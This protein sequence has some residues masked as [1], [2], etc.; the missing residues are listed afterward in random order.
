MLQVKNKTKTHTYVAR[1]PDR[2]ILLIACC[3]GQYIDLSQTLLLPLIEKLVPSSPL[4]YERV[5]QLDL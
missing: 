3:I 1:R 5:T 2:K 4:L